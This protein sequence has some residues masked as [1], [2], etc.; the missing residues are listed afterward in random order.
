MSERSQ[1]NIRIDR[2]LL[3]ELDELARAERVDRSEMARRV[4]DAGMADRRMERALREYRGGS[5]SAWKAAEIAGVSLYEM[6]D[7]IH[8]EGIPYDLDPDVVN[9]LRGGSFI[10][11]VRETP[12]EYGDVP[13][14]V[15]SGIAT[16]R[17]QFRP[18]T[19]STLFI[20]ESSP[21]SGTHFYRANS[22][23]F[24][25]TQE[26][27]ATALGDGAVPA[28]P[29]FL[30]WFRD[31]GNWLVDLADRPVNRMRGRPRKDAVDDGIRRLAAT[32][33]DVKPERIIVVK[34]SI[35]AA[36]RQAAQAAEFT[37]E[38]A[39]LPFPVR[40]WRL[41]YVR[42]LSALV[43]GSRVAGSANPGPRHG[44]G[45]AIVGPRVRHT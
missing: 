8:D 22:N 42:E 19:V 23:L 29:A 35:S 10:T 2:D 31:Q 7:R 11:A 28:G 43:S 20:G 33:R 25:A 17:D 27:F 12:A 15:A 40:Q 45:K 44:G 16:A 38:I 32:I 34:A 39:E 6:L 3:D 13:G 4:L 1:V 24:R 18:A 21:A 36:V 30:H 37:G 41:V 9:E 14:D 5:V 26:A